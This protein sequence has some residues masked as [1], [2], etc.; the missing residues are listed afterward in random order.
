MKGWCTP[1]ARVYIFLADGFEEV[2]ALTVVDMLRR[3]EIDINMVS[4]KNGLSVT[5]SHGITITADSIYKSDSYND[6]DMLILP[7]GPGYNRLMGHEGLRDLLFEYRN[8]N[9]KMAAICAAPSILGMNGLLKGK[10]ATCFPGYEDKLL[11][12]K[13]SK[14]K[15]VVDGNFITSRGLGTAIDFSLAIITELIGKETADKL[16][17]ETQY[18]SKNDVDN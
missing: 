18:F 11:G 5:G 6:G 7:G 15:T 12:A 13:I 9:K 10:N 2:E 1:M 4:I 8:S 14:D 16:A 17:K 3:A